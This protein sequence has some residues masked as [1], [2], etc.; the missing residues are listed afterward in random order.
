ME[1][2][3][4][5]V[6]ISQQYA[7]GKVG[8]DSAVAQLQ[9]GNDNFTL[10]EDKP[11]A[12]LWCGTHPS[13]PSKA[14]INGGVIELGKWISDHP[15][16]TLGEEVATKWKDLPYLF[17]V[18][19]IRTALSIQAHPDRTLARTLHATQPDLYRDPNH[20]PEIAI[21]LTPFEALCRFRPINRLFHI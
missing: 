1:K 5:L 14:K 10:Q 21:A 15:T 16:E 2:V 7:W 6:C 17:K 3:V 8:R 9:D 4:P 11:Y 18:L 19:S 13:G 12:E 20:K